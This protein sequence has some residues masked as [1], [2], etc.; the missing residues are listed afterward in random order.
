MYNTVHQLYNYMVVS[1]SGQD[2]DYCLKVD[3]VTVPNVS[4]NFNLF[5]S[6]PVS[7]KALPPPLNFPMLPRWR[8]NWESGGKS[9]SA[10]SVCAGWINVGRGRGVGQSKETQMQTEETAG[11]TC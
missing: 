5:Y 1:S 2:L 8:V 11:Q 10:T 7:I 6:E 9:R 4:F 3:D